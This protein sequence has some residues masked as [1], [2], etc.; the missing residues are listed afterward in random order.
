MSSIFCNLPSEIVRFIVT[1]L[2]MEEKIALKELN[3]EYKECIEAWFP[4]LPSKKSYTAKSRL[5]KELIET[6]QVLE[7]YRLGK[8]GRNEEKILYITKDNRLRPCECTKFNHTFLNEGWYLENCWHFSACKEGAEKSS[9]IRGIRKVEC[10]RCGLP[11]K[12][13]VTITKRY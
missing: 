9:R 5:L 2:S 10:K 12:K 1:N 6:I 4:N 8:E 11:L 3:K 13:M 7:F